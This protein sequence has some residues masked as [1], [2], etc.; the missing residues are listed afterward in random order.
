MSKRKLF[1][2]VSPD[3]PLVV[4]DINWELCYICQLDEVASDIVS[5]FKIAGFAEN[6]EKSSYHSTAALLKKFQEI[7]ELPSLL[8]RRIEQYDMDNELASAFID[9][10]AIFHKKCLLKFSQ[11]KYDRKVKSIG[12]EKDTTCTETPLTRRSKIS[13]AN[14]TGT[15]FFC[16]LGVSIGTLHSCQTLQIDKRVRKIAEE[17][18]DKK[19]LAQLS[20]GDMVATEAKYHRICLITL[21]NRY[22]DHN[23]KKSEESSELEMIHGIAFS[24]VVTFVEDTISNSDEDTVPVFKLQDLN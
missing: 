21:Y 23:L 1:E 18:C 4:K 24:E 20:E 7:N 9:N 8:Q 19:L 15:C 3:T 6:P 17:M 13:V 2:I 10:K 14:F 11:L 16:N 22:R 5:P 12:T